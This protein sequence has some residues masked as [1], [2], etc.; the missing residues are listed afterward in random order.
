MATYPDQ[1][2]DVKKR[3]RVDIVM[4]LNILFIP[5]RPPLKRNN[6]YKNTTCCYHHQHSH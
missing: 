4:N 6:N 1:R 2:K 5:N 3:M